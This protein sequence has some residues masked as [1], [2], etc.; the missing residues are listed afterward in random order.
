M[1]D[2]ANSSGTLVNS[3]AQ[4]DKFVIVLYVQIR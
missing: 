2:K 1:L 3:D 4:W